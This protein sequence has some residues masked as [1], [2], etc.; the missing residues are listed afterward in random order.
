M[1]VSTVMWGSRK[2]LVPLYE[3]WTLP[4]PASCSQ[5]LTLAVSPRLVFR[6]EV[7]SSAMVLSEMSL[8]CLLCFIELN[9]E[10]S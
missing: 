2:T 8:L 5:L 3:D 9:P 7:V 4:G 1:E 10:L 6:C